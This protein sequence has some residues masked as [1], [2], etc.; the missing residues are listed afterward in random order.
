VDRWVA[1]RAHDLVAGHPLVVDVLRVLTALGRPQTL[2][3]VALVVAV[4]VA[5]GRR[6]AAALVVVATLGAWLVNIGMKD[7]IDR[8]RPAFDEALARSSGAS[9]P[10]GHAMT[11]GGAAAA[12]AIVVRRRWATIAGVA[13][14]VVIAAT[15]VLLGVHWLSDVVV[16][17]LLGG[18]WALSCARVLLRGEEDL[19]PR[20]RASSEDLPRVPRR[21]GEA[22]SR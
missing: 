21:N 16:G 2:V 22:Q 15:R 5:A 17:S 4:L 14:V 19:R 6:R 7:V 10:S 11:S 3:V 20:D 12:V 13:F 9:F 8:T 18:A 1:E